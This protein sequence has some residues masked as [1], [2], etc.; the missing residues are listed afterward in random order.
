MALARVA[1]WIIGTVVLLVVLAG[2]F[3]VFAYATDYG[4]EASVTKRECSLTPPK[5]TVTTKTL[6]IVHTV[7]VTENQCVLVREGNFVVYHI[8]TERT[9]IYDKEGGRC[10]Y[11]SASPSACAAQ[12]LF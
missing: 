8:R 4:V 1:R 3:G 7:D 12:S 11:D 5:L 6:S 2:A 10:I 9:I